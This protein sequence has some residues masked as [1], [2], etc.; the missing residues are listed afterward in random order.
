VSADSTR[1]KG[2]GGEELARKYL[3]RKGYSI[4]DVNYQRPY[5]EVDIIAR[6]GATIVFVEVKSAST[7]SFGHP[8]S[9]VSP[10]KQGRIIRTSLT[11]LS[12]HGLNDSPV[13]FDVLAV[14]PLGDI[15]HVRDAFSLPDDVFM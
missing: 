15:S 2:S 12:T 5:G 10:R 14:G 3:K 6:D 8:L 1:K 7:T 11:Y 13:R 9:W 4:L